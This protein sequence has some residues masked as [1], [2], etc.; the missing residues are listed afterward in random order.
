MPF[1]KYSYIFRTLVDGWSENFYF[2]AASLDS[3]NALSLVEKN[4]IAGW[5][6][7]G[8]TL[9]S[10]KVVEEG[11]LHRGKIIP[12]NYESIPT[13]Y[14]NRNKDVGSV[15]AKIRLNFAGGGG[16]V[17]Q[18]RG[19]PDEGVSPSFIGPSTP[20][21]P[22]ASAMVTYVN[23]L[24][25]SPPLLGKQL[26]SI[27]VEPWKNAVK[28]LPDPDNPT[29]TRVVI[30]SIGAPLTQGAVVYFKGV[31]PL[32]LPW[33]QGYYRVVGSLTTTQ[34]SIPTVYRES[35]AEFSLRN[36]QWRQALY[37]YPAI[38]GGAFLRF[39]S[40]DTAGPFGL[41]RGAKRGRKIRQ[42]PLVAG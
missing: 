26:T 17:V 42:S 38:V 19:L 36:V 14:T 41:S 22:L 15:A 21:A 3:F 18:A 9:L 5:R 23:Y 2:E 1:F 39:G 35:V 4:A 7:R 24:K 30:E 6:G 10:V 13:G 31:D 12:V 33:I 29:W 28:L 11:G 37:T 20:T 25:G 8:V 32:V 34:F 27:A 16:R 40:R